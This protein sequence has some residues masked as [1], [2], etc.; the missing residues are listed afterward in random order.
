MTYNSGRAISELSFEDRELL[1]RLLAFTPGY[2]INTD[3]TW[4]Q[5]QATLLAT[6]PLTLRRPRALLPRLAL[7]L[8]S[9]AP[10]AVLCPTHRDLHP[11]LIHTIFLGISAECTTHLERFVEDEHAL[12]EPLR[13]LFRSLQPFV[14]RLQEVNGLWMSPKFYRTLFAPWHDDAANFQFE[15]IHSDCEACILASVGGNHQVLSDLR[16]SILGRKKKGH[17]HATVLQM[18]EAWIDWTGNANII[19]EESGKLG[20]LIVKCRRDMQKLRRHKRRG[21]AEALVEDQE[22]DVESEELIGRK[23]D[24]VDEDTEDGHYYEEDIIDFYAKRISTVGPLNGVSSAEGLHEAFRESFVRDPIHGTFHRA[25]QKPRPY[26]ESVYSSNVSITGKS[27]YEAKS[28]YNFPKCSEKYA[29]SYQNVL[30]IPED[31]EPEWI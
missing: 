28:L 5:G 7:H 3:P 31:V 29:Q 16:A 30:N 21:V 4:L 14:R 22:M 11:H 20:R 25:V 23:S 6:F 9:A 13:S 18:V 15:R 24:G 2:P 1:A 17:A 8:P 27:S 26:S 12:P 10:Q 19:R